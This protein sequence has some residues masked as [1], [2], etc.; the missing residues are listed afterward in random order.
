MALCR[1][2]WSSA[3]SQPSKAWLSSASVH[4]GPT[5]TEVLKTPDTVEEKLKKLRHIPEFPLIYP[6][7]LQSPVWGRRNALRERLERA[8][9]LER[10]MQLDIP[11]FYVGSIVAVTT[12]DSNLANRQNRFLGICIR[13]EREGLQHQFTLR[14]VV[15]GL[16]VEVMYELYNPTIL[17]IET[18]K[19]ERR[20]DDDLSYLIDALP[21]YSTFD[22]NLEPIA[23]P[24]GTPVPVNA[25]KI[26]LRPPPW[27][28]RWEL[29]D[30]K[31]IEDSWTQATPYYKRRLH[32]TRVNDYRKY[33]LIADYRLKSNELEHELAVEKE[34]ARFEAERHQSGATRRR[35][36]RAASQPTH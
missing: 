18:I 28:R 30:Y 20:L 33:D 9:M 24:A 21:E 31:G 26:K 11:E 14:N 25:Q 6:D 27:T 29:Y 10:R 23:H 13:R 16:G 32:K 15:D 4:S 5:K 36:L 7:F 22:F 19:L 3:T 34:M 2:L 17:K 35:I 1:R 12:S 8:D